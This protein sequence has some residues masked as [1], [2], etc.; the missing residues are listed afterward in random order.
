MT[1][2]AD[3][4]GRRST[5]YPTEIERGAIRRFAEAVGET[6]PIFLMSRPRDNKAT[7]MW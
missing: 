2:L 7:G 4:V 3:T 6:D 5:P 1:N